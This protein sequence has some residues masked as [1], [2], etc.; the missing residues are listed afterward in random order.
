MWGGG[1]GGK[2]DS[3]TTKILFDD[4]QNSIFYGTSEKFT[5]GISFVL[6]MLLIFYIIT[7]VEST[8][9]ADFPI[10]HAQNVNEH[11]SVDC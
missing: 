5:G 6:L 8:E 1:G 2:F 10:I 3:L 9:P 11:K 4:K 7:K